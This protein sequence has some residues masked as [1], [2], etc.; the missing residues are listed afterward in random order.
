LIAEERISHSARICSP[1]FLRLQN[2]EG[3]GVKTK[4]T[5][6]KYLL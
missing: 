1:I 4:K 2:E 3:Y 5:K 6:T